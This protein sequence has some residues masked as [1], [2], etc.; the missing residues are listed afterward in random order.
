M[1]GVL[2]PL[3]PA[4]AA[5]PYITETPQPGSF[6]LAEPG[7]SA[8]LVASSREYP[9]VLRVAGHLQND[10]ARV[11]GSAP[12]LLLDTP[13]AAGDVILFGTLGV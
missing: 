5:L 10:L 11:T 7:R 12:A 8:Y 2:L 6:T 3:L 13:P 4:A 9:G 1:F